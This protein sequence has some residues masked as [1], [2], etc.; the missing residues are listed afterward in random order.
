MTRTGPS[1]GWSA[2]CRAARARLSRPPWSRRLR[3]SRRAR[4]APSGWSR[5]RR[6][7]RST[8]RSLV[9]NFDIPAEVRSAGLARITVVV[10][11]T[12]GEDGRVGRV[13]VLR[14]HALIPDD[15]IVRAVERSHFTPA[16]MSD[17]A[18]YAAIHTLPITLAITL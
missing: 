16:R 1:T 6:R 17:G 5:V 2:A 12:V 7:R 3:P 9:R 18:P 15:V 11:V 4:A 8:A 13:E 10:R 14:G